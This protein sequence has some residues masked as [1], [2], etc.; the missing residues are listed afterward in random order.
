MNEVN[1][2]KLEEY[3]KYLRCEYPRRGT[4]VGHTQKHYYRFTRY[5]LKWIE[6]NKNKTYNEITSKDLQ[7]YRIYC[8]EKYKQNG[9]VCRLNAVKN[10]TVKFL[11]RKKLKIPVLSSIFVNKPILSKE[12]LKKYIE[13]AE[14]PLEK[15]IVIYQVDALLRPGDFYRLKISCHDCKN[16]ILYTNE[17]KSGDT[18]VILTPYMEKAFK[19]YLL[20]RVTP[21][22]KEDTDML[23]IIDKGTHRGLSPSPI[24]QCIYRKTK[25]IAARAGFTRSVYPYLIKPSAI[26]DKFNDG[27]PPR[28]I[29]R[30]SRHRKVA[31]TLRY[32]QTDDKLVKEYFNRVQKLNTDNPTPEDKAKV[33]FD[34]LLS[35]EIDL[36]TFKT[37]IALLLPDKDKSKQRDEDIG[38]M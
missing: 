30:Q 13:S 5:F 19:E 20:Y 17:S 1:E 37:G 4:K 12:E 2:E 6:E 21:K 35:N 31:Y 7:D 14:T 8:L 11:G 15:L 25:K 24:S 36:K 22:R 10:F 28:I 9:N 34:K 33:W 27:V 38:Y 23:I 18:S 26:T 32:D 3:K 16:Q 29:Q